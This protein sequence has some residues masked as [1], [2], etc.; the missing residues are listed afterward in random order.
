[1]ERNSRGNKSKLN[2]KHTVIH[3]RE[4]GCTKWWACRAFVWLIGGYWWWLRTIVRK[5]STLCTTRALLVNLLLKLPS[6]RVCGGQRTADGEWRLIPAVWLTFKVRG[7]LCKVLPFPWISQPARDS[8]ERQS[9][10]NNFI[11]G[12]SGERRWL[13]KLFIRRFSE[14]EILKKYIA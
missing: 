11:E 8:Y 10:R 13:R 3:N 9:H 5:L 12:A 14:R 6:P 7:V 2:G 1:M 4:A